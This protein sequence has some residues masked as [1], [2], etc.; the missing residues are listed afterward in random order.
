MNPRTDEI[1]ERFS[2]WLDRYSPPRGI[3][4]APKAMQ[5]EADALLNCFLKTAPTQGYTQWVV[6]KLDALSQSMTTRAWPTVGE[7]MKVLKARSGSSSVKNDDAVEAAC[8]DAMEKWFAKF[9]NEMPSMGRDSRTAELIRRGVLA[10]ERE[11]RFRGFSLHP[12]SNRKAKRLPM[13]PEEWAHHVRVS[14]QI[15]GND[16][17]TQDA[18]CAEWMRGQSPETMPA[19]FRRMEAREYD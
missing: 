3:S 4:N 17:R 19:G 8:V 10:D 12:D 15:T 14:A 18:I 5:Q 2:E 13:W 7:A 16:I 1:T 9:K 11:A 6:D